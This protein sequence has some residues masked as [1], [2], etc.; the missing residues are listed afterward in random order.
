MAIGVHY[1][2]MR[3]PINLKVA[4]ILEAVKPRIQMLA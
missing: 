1:A 3:P 2:P 4:S